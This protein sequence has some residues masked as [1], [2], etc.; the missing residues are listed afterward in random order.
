M[1]VVLLYILAEASEL[2]NFRFGGSKQAMGYVLIAQHFGFV[3]RRIVAFF[4]HLCYF[5]SGF[6]L[7]LDDFPFFPMVFPMVFSM[8][9]PWFSQAPNGSWFSLC[10]AARARM[11]DE[12]GFDAVIFLEEDLEVSPDF[13]SCPDIEK[14]WDFALEVCIQFISYNINE[15]THVYTRTCIYMFTQITNYLDVSLSLYIYIC[16][17]WIFTLSCQMLKFSFGKCFYRK[18]GQIENPS[19]Q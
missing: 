10:L 14:S 1:R 7:V 11:F 18:H 12:F 6:P 16:T 8:I 4:G 5:G 9:C 15:V 17:S 2:A 3:M 13:F 19:A